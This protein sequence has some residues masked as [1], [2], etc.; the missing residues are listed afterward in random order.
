[1]DG[2]T[3]NASLR[4]AGTNSGMI[5]ASLGTI[6]ASL[7]QA[8]TDGEMFDA[9]GI[10]NASLRQTGTDGGIDASTRNAGAGRGSCRLESKYVQ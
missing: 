5:D 4:Q 10:I 6:N 8:G 9:C 1:M 3:I 7:R 2:G